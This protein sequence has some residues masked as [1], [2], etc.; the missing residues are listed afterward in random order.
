MLHTQFC[1][2]SAESTVHY[3]T[4]DRSYS[5]FVNSV[6]GSDSVV[7]GVKACKDA[8]LALSEIPGITTYNT[9]EVIIGFDSNTQCSI[10]TSVG[11]EP[12]VS[13]Y[14]HNALDCEV[15]KYFWVSWRK[16]ALELGFGSA[17]GSGTILRWA[18]AVMH[19]VNAISVMTPEE[20]SATW[21]F[22][23]AQGK[24]WF[25]ISRV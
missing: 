8:R 9:Y 25:M 24:F 16:N 5:S 1:S 4:G 11:A 22:R 12:V 2:R 20:V 14:A 17:V 19:P 18:S 6:S 13:A 3:K 10:A 15:L 7:F 23:V 21:E